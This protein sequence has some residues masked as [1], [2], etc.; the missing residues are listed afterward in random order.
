MRT[1]ANRPRQEL[2][3]GQSSEP[4]GHEQVGLGG[5]PFCA[6]HATAEQEREKQLRDR[7]ATERQ[8]LVEVYNSAGGDGWWVATY[9]LSYRPV[10]DWFGVTTGSNGIVP[11]L[12]LYENGLSDRILDQLG[13]PSD[14]TTLQIFGN[15]LSGCIPSGL[16]AQLTNVRLGT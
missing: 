5:L 2:R 7:L 3:A 9:W 8:V 10:S 1:G 16:K 15:R 11:G 14:L 12:K 13:K 6:E 4:T